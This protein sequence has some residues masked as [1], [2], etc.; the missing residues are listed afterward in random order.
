MEDG[1]ATYAHPP[2]PP[3]S[4]PPS[5]ENSGANVS[6]KL[7]IT[8]P[9]GARAGQ[10]LK[11]NTPNHGQLTI[12]VPEGLGPG[13]EMLVTVKGGAAPPP[14]A[15]QICITVPPGS[16]PGTKLKANSGSPSW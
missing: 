6:S 13:D 7:K 1:G 5:S 4:A 8:L 9:A 15:Q 2:P 12:S 14:P 10:T 16:I 11:V 3:P